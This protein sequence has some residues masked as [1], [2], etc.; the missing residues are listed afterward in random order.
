MNKHYR[1]TSKFRF[2]IFL[3]ILLLCVIT[4]VSTV[5]GF[6]TVNSASR[7]VY[8]QV[9]IRSGDT[10]WNIASEYNSKDMDVRKVI[11]DICD[12]NEISADQLK[13]GQ[14]ILVPVY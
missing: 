6:N 9:Q 8:N 14:K 3:A 2:T 4:I 5:L 12:I 13:V 10:L 11:N 1:I 7:N